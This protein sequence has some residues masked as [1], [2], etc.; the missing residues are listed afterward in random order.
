IVIFRQRRELHFQITFWGFGFPSAAWVALTTE[1][2]R[3]CQLDW[4]GAAGTILWLLLLAGLIFLS[5]YTLTRMRT[6]KIYQR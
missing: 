4:L 1:L 6:G 2:A 3:H 5:V